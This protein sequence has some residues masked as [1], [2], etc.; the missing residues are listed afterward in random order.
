MEINQ[1]IAEYYDELYPVTEEQ[2]VFYSK[3][4]EMF[5]KPVRFLRIGC[6][7]G[8]FEHNL[9][10]DGSDVTGLETSPELL[11]SANRKRRTQLMAVR[12]FQMQVIE[13]SRFLGKQF[14]NIISILDNRLLFSHDKTL[15][16]KFFY[17]CKQVLSDN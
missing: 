8:S 17:D 4:M 2:K 15:M 6:G 7:T 9:A 16:A 12:Y 13:M 11:E 10:K 1:N 5:K 14:Y 3:K